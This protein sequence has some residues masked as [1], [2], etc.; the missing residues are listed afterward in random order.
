MLVEYLGAKNILTD[1]KVAIKM[2][3]SV[4]E[5]VLLKVWFY[6]SDLDVS[7]FRIQ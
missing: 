3:V 7:F 1:I 5:L 6:I 4:P 2:R